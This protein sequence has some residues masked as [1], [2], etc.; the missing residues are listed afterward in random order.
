MTHD[1]MPHAWEFDD[2]R[3]RAAT[4]RARAM[5]AL[6]L[7]HPWVPGVLSGMAMAAMGRYEDAVYDNRPTFPPIVL[8]RFKRKRPSRATP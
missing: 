8:P 2:R 5:R 1:T 4:A 6:G 7:P 3:R